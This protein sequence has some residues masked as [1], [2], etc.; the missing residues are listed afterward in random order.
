MQ[1]IG[2]KQL[3]LYHLLWPRQRCD[4]KAFCWKY[5]PDEFWLFWKSAGSSRR[6]LGNMFT[7]GWRQGGI[8][9]LSAGFRPPLELAHA[10][11]SSQQLNGSGNGVWEKDR[12]FPCFKQKQ[13]AWSCLREHSKQQENKGM[14]W[15]QPNLC[16]L[17]GFFPRIDIKVNFPD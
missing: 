11:G 12:H 2:R 8:S 6:E 16:K 7:P 13:L 3:L 1:L 15:F 9:P 17:S 10:L 5:F 14:R 4:Y